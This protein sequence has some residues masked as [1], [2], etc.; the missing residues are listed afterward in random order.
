MTPLDDLVAGTSLP[1]LVSGFKKITPV[2]GFDAGNPDNAKQNDYAWAVADLGDYLYV[3]TGRNIV[4]AVL[5]S[6][7]FGDIPV[8]DVF[9]PKQLDMNAEIWRYKKDGSQGWQRVYKAPPESGIQGIRFLIQYTTPAG[10]TALYAGCNTV[11]PPVIVLKSTD[12][13][14]WLELPS[15][16]S[17]ANSTRAMLVHGGILY[18][19]VI[20]LSA[21]VTRLYASTDPER[22]G[23]QLVDLAGDPDKNPR[24]AI[25]TLISFNDHLYMA[26]SRV[27][28]FELWRTEGFLPAKD[29]W[30]L[31][32]D[33]GAGDALNEIP[34]STGVFR[35]HLYVG[36][37]ITFAVV[38]LNPQRRFVPPKGF[39]L[40][41]VDRDDNWELVVGGDPIDPTYPSTGVRGA[42]LSGYPGGFGNLAAG[43]CWQIQ[44]FDKDL[45]LGTWDWSDLIPVLLPEVL[46]QVEGQFPYNTG[47]YLES[48][49]EYLNF[50][51]LSNPL[52]SLFPQSAESALTRLFTPRL[53]SW[54]ENFGFDLWRSPDGVRWLPVSLNGL[55][56]PYNY[57]L[58]NLFVADGDLYLGTANPFQGCEVW[59]KQK[60][61]WGIM[62]TPESIY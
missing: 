40:V 60:S 27:G 19:G 13:V 43:Y 5:S 3:G 22:E 39:D 38:S 9:V 12:G 10:E 8:P 31:V 44:P 2:N 37:A 26:T 11:R 62:A 17:F 56:N 24:G 20:G 51:L 15:G 34:L 58:R 48:L 33:K 18:M 4:Y 41:R 29:N 42:P 35:G 7:L 55:D 16:I 21:L 52:F 36:T 61:P 28:G 49:K 53:R 32:I 47:N 46:G 45:F 59:L 25:T 57:G 54:Q 14:N 23:W 30:K 6:G 50:L 1:T